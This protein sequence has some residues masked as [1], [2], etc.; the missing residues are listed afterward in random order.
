MPSGGPLV[1]LSGLS[2]QLGGVTQDAKYEV[3]NVDTGKKT[4]HQGAELADLRVTA[5][6]QPAAVVLIYR[7][8]K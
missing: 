8:L 1:R 5:A 3:E 2:V 6:S 7:R 4:V